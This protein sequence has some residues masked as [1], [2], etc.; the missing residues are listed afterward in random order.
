MC[1][2]VGLFGYG[3]NGLSAFDVSLFQQMLYA[4]G[5]RGMHG[6]G[7]FSVDDQG[8]M[9]RVRIGGPPQQLFQSQAYQELEAAARKGYPRFLVGHNRYA[10][11]G[12]R[13]T[14]NSHPFRDGHITLVHNGTLENY[15]HLPDFKKYEVDSELLTHAIAK[16]GVENTIPTLEGAWTIVYW[17]GQKKTLNILRNGERPLFM[18]VHKTFEM[19]AIASERDMLEWI[20]RRNNNISHV[21]SEVPTDTLFSFSLDK[22]EPVAKSLA[23]KPSRSSKGSYYEMFGGASDACGTNCAA[24][25][26]K[27]V[28]NPPKV[29]AAPASGEWKNGKTGTVNQSHHRVTD[30]RAAAHIVKDNQWKGVEFIH[31]L[32]LEQWIEL[33]VTDYDPIKDSKELFQVRCYLDGYPDIE[34]RANIKGEDVLDGLIEAPKFRAQITSI[35]QS[36]NPPAAHAHLVYVHHPEPL[37]PST[38]KESEPTPANAQN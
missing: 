15:R 25:S 37:F 17:D 24:N 35:R 11:K 27:D 19:I 29:I 26:D 3:K 14:E 16:D 6:T 38:T 5:L 34:F 10:T 22:M 20:L 33:E 32:S 1:G 9:R 13:T 21:I 28:K 12:A 31:D 18:A 23:G 7:M 30:K 36:L 8:N 4:D 2:I